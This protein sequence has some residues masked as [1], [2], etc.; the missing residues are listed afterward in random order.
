MIFLKPT[1]T[2]TAM[3]CAILLAGLPADAA[4]GVQV[5]CRGVT[6]LEAKEEIALA[7]VTATEPRINFIANPGD[8]TP[9]CS[10]AENSQPWRQ[11]VR[12]G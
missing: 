2:L 5:D 3:L 6:L 7:R 12:H 1:L 9:D 4:F 11:F 10:S 8:R